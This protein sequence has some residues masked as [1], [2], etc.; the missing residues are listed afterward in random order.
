MLVIE[1]TWVDK[2]ILGPGGGVVEVLRGKAKAK[3]KRCEVTMQ[4][5]SETDEE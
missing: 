5:A 1:K 4:D 2:V 3:V